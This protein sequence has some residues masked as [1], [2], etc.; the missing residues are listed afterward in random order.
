MIVW[1]DAY[2]VGHDLFDRQHRELLDILNELALL[3]KKG[4]AQKDLFLI[5]NRLIKYTEEHFFCEEELM[6][7]LDFP[8]YLEH[9][10]EHEGLV[11]HI[12]E[13]HQ[14]YC[15]HGPNITDE[16]LSFLKDWVLT[17]IL[18]TDMK[19]KPFFQGL[20]ELGVASHR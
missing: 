5:F 4:V 1:S 2:S 3:K 18:G 11:E 9:K 17:H 13:L 19:Y 15:K 8:G 20:N 12:F 16:V 7:E 14:D 10:E 6:K